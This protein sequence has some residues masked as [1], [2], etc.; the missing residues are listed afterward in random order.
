MRHSRGMTDITAQTVTNDAMG[1]ELL[2][3]ILSEVIDKRERALLFA[4]VALDLPL[5]SVARTLGQD[6]KTVEATIASLL[7][8][9][10]EAEDFRSSLS[11]VRKAGRAEHYLELATKLGLRDWF[12]AYCKRFI[13]QPAVG[14]PR[15]TC[16]DDCRTRRNRGTAPKQTRP[17]SAVFP[18]RP[19]ALQVTYREAEAMRGVLGSVI[20]NLDRAR[21]VRLSTA[22]ATTRNRALILL[23]FA[24]PV[25]LSPMT[26]T[27]L[28]MD[29]VIETRESLEILFRWGARPTKQYVKIPTDPKSA[30][31][32]VRA[33]RAWRA[34][35][36]QQGRRSGPLFEMLTRP[37]ERI[38]ENQTKLPSWSAAS[39]IEK[40]I[41]DAGL[42]PSRTLHGGVLLPTYLKEV[43]VN[44]IGGIADAPP[45]VS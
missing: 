26:L 35:L 14:R 20:G 38:M 13:I 24:C 45:L 19:S 42:R 34:L 23:G 5:A 8:R 27:D 16:G 36:R 33:V 7:A 30:L 3:R 9:L 29:N 18:Q 39:L 15:I 4:H 28:V 10:K 22:E 6:R 21:D 32:P 1:D 11:D 12:C 31:C 40:A 37:D 2:L 43:A 44:P 25:Q 41:R 17:G